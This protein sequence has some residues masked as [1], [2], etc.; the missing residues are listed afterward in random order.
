[1]PTKITLFKHFGDFYCLYLGKSYPTV[2]ASYRQKSYTLDN[3]IITL[4]NMLQKT[5][6]C[7]SLTLIMR[8]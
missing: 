8:V 4:T 6:D 1:M 7:Y 5:Y 2:Q 3:L